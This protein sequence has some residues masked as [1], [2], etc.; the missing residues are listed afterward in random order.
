VATKD[1]ARAGGVADRLDELATPE[2]LTASRALRPAILAGQQN[3]D[4]AI[5]YLQGLGRDDLGTQI[6]LLRAYLASG[7]TAKAQSLA[8][9]MLAKAPKD[10]AVR[11]IAAAIAAAAGDPAGAEAT[12]RALIEEDPSRLA[13]WNVLIRQMVQEGKLKEA[14]ADTDAA[15]TH[16]PDAPDLLLLKAGFLEQHHDAEG[17]IAIYEKLYATQSGNLVVANDL[18]SMLSATHT[19]PASLDRAWAIAR[20][21]N[22]TTVPAFADT[23]GWILNLRGQPDAALPY[24]ETAAKGMTDNPEVQFHLAEVYRALKRPDDAK[25]YYAKVLALV[26]ADDPRDFV[27]V[28]RTQSGQN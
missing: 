14:E 15:L 28:A 27:K 12:F 11:F 26:P 1:W 4:A 13:V 19:D 18:A 16:L 8:Q 10:A 5:G 24:L 9:D 3:V 21:L 25:A 23:Y 6:T 20:R 2:A 7:Q 22:G 17:A